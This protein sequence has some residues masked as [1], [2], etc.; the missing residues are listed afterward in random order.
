M[1]G[2]VKLTL[3]YEGLYIMKLTE[4]KE[5]VNKLPEEELGNYT[6]VYRT[7]GELGDEEHYAFDEPITASG[8]DVDNNEIYLCNEESHK[9]IQSYII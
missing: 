1:D 5:W 3:Q 6:V 2:Y 9:L 4:L 8:V 7:I